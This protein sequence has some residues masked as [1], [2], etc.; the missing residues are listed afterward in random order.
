MTQHF[1]S[2]FMLAGLLALGLMTQPAMAQMGGS[3]Q[4]KFLKAVREGNG[5]DAGRLMEEGG[6]TMVNTQDDNTGETALH[7]TVTKRSAVW[8]RYMLQ[9]GADPNLADK[10]KTTPLMLATQLAFVEGVEALLNNKAKV[11]AQNKFGET[12]LILAVHQLDAGLVRQLLKAG[13]NPDKYDYSGQSARTYAER[14]PRA[15]SIADIIKNGVTD[16]PEK[17]KQGKLDF[18]GFDME[19]EPKPDQ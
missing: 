19:E 13:A 9:N 11:D 4:S 12:A 18:S 6:S 17:P 7:I 5:G 8:T 16:E 2:K 3:P 14:D 15:R 10:K 1:F